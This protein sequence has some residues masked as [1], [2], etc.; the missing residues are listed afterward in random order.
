MNAVAGVATFGNLIFIGANSYTLTASSPGLIPGS[1]VL[2]IG[3]I[4]TAAA[5][6]TINPEPSSVGQSYS[7]PYTVTATGGTAPGNVVVTDGATSNACT[8]LASTC[9]LKSTTAG[10]KTITVAYAGDSNFAGSSATKSHTVNPASTT[11][12]IGAINPEPSAVGQPYSVAYTITSTG[13]TPT[14]NVTVTDGSVSNT[15]TVGLATCSLTSTTVGTKNVSVTYA[16]DGNF[17]GSS[18]TAAHT[19]MATPTPSVVSLVPVSSTGT[20]QNLIF[21]FAHPS[22]YSNLTVMN[23]LINTA[24]DGRQGCY[25]VYVQQTNTLYL[26]NDA[27]DAG[28]PF[29]GSVVLNGSG[30]AANSQCTI[31][32]VGS[33]AAG[34]GTGF[35]LTLNMTFSQAFGGNKIVYAAARDTAQNNSGWQTMGVR[36]VPP[37]PA[38]FPNP[39]GMNPPSGTG[40]N[41]TLTFTYQDAAAALN[42]QTAWALINTALD[43]RAACYVAYYRPG[44]LLLLIPDNGDGTQATSMVLTGTNSV[45][46]GQCSVSAQGSSATTSG[47][48]LMLNLNITFK[49]AFAGP[50]AVWMAAQTLGGQTSPWQ[51]LGAW[52]PQ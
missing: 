15:C 40:S 35:T 3:G 50:K 4:S 39:L 30:S 36:G 7:V 48:Q 13:G 27:G 49:P 41:A 31:T 22:G 12:L 43:G 38:T 45:S 10:T 14:G 16:G 33:S 1:S 34:S 20:T 2:N 28:A 46:N 47:S 42:L 19:V 18:A 44:N 5:I 8:V 52:R 21:Q 23:V 32:A 51:A 6:G 25:I 29:A 24:L 17:A 9:S 37:L 26:V 11:T